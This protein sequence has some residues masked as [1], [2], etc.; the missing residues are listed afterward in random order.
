MKKTIDFFLYALPLIVAIIIFLLNDQFLLVTKELP[1]VENIIESII[2]YTSIIIGVLIALFGIVV[3]LTDKDIMKKLQKN[4]KDNTIFRYCVE[5][6]MSNFFL[7]AISI[8]LQS[9]VQFRNQIPYTQLLL[10]IWVSVVFFATV[11]SI[12]TIYYLL[13][14]SFN[15]N[16]HSVRPKS[17]YTINDDERNKF[18]QKKSKIKE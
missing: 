9:I 2:N 12:R 10:N 1:G 6:L 13:L 7:L 16:D 4:N 14:I 8:I 15:Q 5:T 18:M 3:A 17:N 11:S